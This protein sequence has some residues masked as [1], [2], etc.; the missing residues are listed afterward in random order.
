MSAIP[1]SL[2]CG[3]SKW[4]SSSKTQQTFTFTILIAYFN[5]Q[6][7]LGFAFIIRSLAQSCALHTLSL[8]ITWDVMDKMWDV[9]MCF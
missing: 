5:K 1:S 2:S 6:N 3:T 7:E 8:G 4:Q 9:A